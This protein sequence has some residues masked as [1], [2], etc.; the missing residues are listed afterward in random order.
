MNKPANR[1]HGRQGTSFNSLR[2]IDASAFKNASSGVV[3]W[4]SVLLIWVLSLLPWRHWEYAPDFLMLV[5]AFWTLHEPR[6]VNM[7]MAFVLGL[8]MDAHDTSFLG[9][10]A[11]SYVLACYGVIALSRRLQ[12]FGSFAQMIYL[13]P[14]FF[15]ASA[16][17]RFLHAW[18]AGEW[19]GWSWCLAAVFT[20]VLWPLADFLLLLPHRRL[21]EADDGS[22]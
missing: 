5:L 8:L 6:K 14:V 10:H 18:F 11:M 22:A 15:I 20:G 16:I 7:T 17:P 1:D 2:P 12:L 19:G 3:V 13:L 21:D 9:E 4:G